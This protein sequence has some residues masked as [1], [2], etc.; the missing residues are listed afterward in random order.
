MIELSAMQNNGGLKYS[1]D[2]EIKKILNP[3]KLKKINPMAL[4]FYEILPWTLFIGLLF[5]NAIL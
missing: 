3:E 4:G 5:Y 2:F 1:E